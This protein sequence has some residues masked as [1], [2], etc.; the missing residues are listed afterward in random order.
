M[1]GGMSQYAAARKFGVSQ[2]TM[3]FISWNPLWGERPNRGRQIERSAEIEERR[4]L[5]KA[6]D[7][8]RLVREKLLEMKRG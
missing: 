3:N 4:Q 2:T 7:A 5:A 6:W 8:L 1:L